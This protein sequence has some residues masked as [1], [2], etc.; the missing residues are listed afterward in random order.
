MKISNILFFPIKAKNSVSKTQTK[1]FDKNKTLKPIA[2]SIKKIEPS[3]ETLG[4]LTSFADTNDNLVIPDTF[5]KTKNFLPNNWDIVDLFIK[6]NPNIKYCMSY[7][8][9]YSYKDNFW[10]PINKDQLTRLFINFLKLN[11][12]KNYK[13]FNLRNLD[14]IFLLISQN[15]EF[16]MPDAI[17]AVTSN[18]FLLPFQNGVLN[19]KTFELTS[20]S[21]SN[22]TTHFIPLDYVKEHSIKNTKF[23]EFLT[24]LVNNNSM[25]LKILRACLYLI[26]TNNLI[27]QIALYIY[28]PG[29]TGKSTFT[30][31]LMYL[32]GKEVTLS[33]SIQQINSKF[34]LASIVGKILLI[35]NDVSLFRGQEPKNIKNIVTQDPMEAEIKYKQPFMFTP[36]SFLVITSNVLWDIKNTTSGLSRRMVYIPFDNVPNFKEMDLFRI[37]PNG[38]AVGSL[39]PHFGG[40]INWVLTCP[41]NFQDILNDGGSK[42]TELISPDSIHVNPLNIFV[43][44]CLLNEKDAV[45]KL[46]SRNVNNDTLFGVYL[47]W[48]DA[49]GITP[50]TYKSFSILILDLL[51]Q[52][53]WNISRKRIASGIIIT[54]I[55]ANGNW[56]YERLKSIENKEFI[57]KIKDRDNILTNPVTEDDF[58]N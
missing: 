20:H 55:R 2:N 31:I 16:S 5:L 6:Q 3:A 54:G 36:N 10:A 7:K 44:D 48:A 1:K 25:R 28:G 15:E 47:L 21:P 45:I 33:T 37:L 24:S 52:L 51:K 49:N 42:I 4:N 17:S 14:E 40:F 13:K 12:P 38:F 53:G 22:Y 58:N 50:I 46:G 8:T 35:L 29:G 41:K 43:K 57:P 11:Y 56:N 26:F 32:L 34:G 30:N 18:G 39:L 23:A 27:Y 19:T 9:F